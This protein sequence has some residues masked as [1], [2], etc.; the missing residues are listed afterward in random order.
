MPL[1]LEHP[2]QMLGRRR[3]FPAGRLPDQRGAVPI[4]LSLRWPLRSPQSG[5]DPIA[6]RCSTE[7][8]GFALVSRL[9]G[10]DH[11]P[12]AQGREISWTERPSESSDR[13]DLANHRFDAAAFA[14]GGSGCK[15]RILKRARVTPG[16]IKAEAVCDVVQTHAKRLGLKAA[17]FRRPFLASRL[18]DQRSAPRCFAAGAQARAVRHALR[19]AGSNPRG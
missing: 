4:A 6:F 15:P 19:R 10:D 13:K 12:G 14:A 2:P 5:R 8:S 3:G 18:P 11:L 9:S 1:A 16:P 17:D 7:G